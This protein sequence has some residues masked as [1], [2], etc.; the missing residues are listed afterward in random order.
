[1]CKKS[2]SPPFSY[3]EN[4]KFS[5]PE[6]Q[7]RYPKP[8]RCKIFPPVGV[9]RRRKCKLLPADLLLTQAR[10]VRTLAH[11]VVASQEWEGSSSQ[12]ALEDSLLLPDMCVRLI[13]DHK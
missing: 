5:R 7:G 13:L 11:L 10:E 2:K 9:D 3:Y 1:M 6:Y 12:L 4:Q 8:L